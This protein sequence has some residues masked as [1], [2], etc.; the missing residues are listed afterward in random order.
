MIT[1]GTFVAFQSLMASFNQPIVSLVNLGSSLQDV[2]AGLKRIED[3]FNYPVIRPDPVSEGSAGVGNTVKL[4]GYVELKEITFGYSSLESPLISDFSLHLS[5]GSRVAI[6]GPTGCGKSTL[7]NLVSGLYE[8][9]K[10]EV[11]FDG[12]RR[13]DIA[14]VTLNNSIAMVDQNLF[15]FEGTV[16]ENIS[17]WDQTVAD[18]EVIQAA[19]DAC[20]HEDIAARQGAYESKVE[21]NGRNFSNGQRQRIEIA[22]ALAAKPSILIL[23]EATSALDAM[24]EHMIDNNIRKKGCTCLIIAHR[25]STIR[26]CDEIVV[27]D[28][29]KIVERGTHQ[30]LMSQGGLY[31]ELVKE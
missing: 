12:R 16:K 31:C 5:P 4:Q 15:L 20:I 30:E 22:R 29:G 9:W 18:K 6:V 7:A 2:Q 17:F 11:L 3:V 8:P 1:V 27:M 23:D 24:T 13:A 28:N 25:L 10:G 21:E 19:K 14:Q 26:D